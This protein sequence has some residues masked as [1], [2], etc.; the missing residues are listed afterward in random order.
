MLFDFG[1]EKTCPRT[2]RRNLIIAIV[3][4]IFIINIIS[5]SDNNLK[6]VFAAFSYI[7][8]LFSI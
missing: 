3:A 4:M 8:K 1:L 5:N 7:L 6:N 2:K